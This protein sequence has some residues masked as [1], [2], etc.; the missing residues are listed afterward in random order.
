[1][2]RQ[3][4]KIFGIDTVGDYL[5]FCDAAVA[6]LEQQQDNV[7]R[8]F[9]AILALNHVPDW[10]QYKLTSAERTK[11]GIVDVKVGEPVKDHF[12]ALNADLKRVRDIA[13]GFKHL[14]PVHSTQVV[15]G[16]GQGPYG[17]GPYGAPYLLID[18]GEHLPLNERWDVGLSLC[19]RVLGWWKSRL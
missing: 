15:E 17:I 16:Y 3:A 7:L 18:L 4:T 13:N 6:E 1:M 5:A 19:Q 12:E 14:K 10:L 8:A 11:L 2:S 9:T